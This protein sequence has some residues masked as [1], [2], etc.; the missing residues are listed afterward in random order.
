MHC[1]LVQLPEFV[2]PAHIFTEYAYFSSYSTTWVEHAGRYCEM[3][4]TRLGLGPKSFVVELGSN[5]GYLL[6]AFRRASACRCSASSPPPM[7]RKTAR[8]RPAS[9]RSTPSSAPKTAKEVVAEHGHADLIVA[10]NVLAQVPELNDFV[11]G[12]AHLLAPEGVI[13]IEVPHLE[14]LMDGEPVRYDLSRAF[15]VFLARHHDPPRCGPWPR[16]DRRRDSADAWRIACASISRISGSRHPVSIGWQTCWRRSAAPGSKPRRLCRLCRPGSAHQA[17]ASLRSH[18]GQGGRQA[19][20]RLRRAGKGQHARSTTPV[21]APISWTS[22]S[23]ATRTSTAAT[24]RACTSRSSRSKRSTQAKPD[25]ILILPWNLKQEIVA[26]DAPCRQVGRASSSF[27]SRRSRSST[28]IALPP[29]R[30]TPR[31]T[32]IIDGDAA[33]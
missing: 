1:W 32:G 24:R 6:Q 33:G 28:R 4:K 8:A 7:W 2:S 12:M 5:D 22:R 21:S 9:R 30:H 17:R 11:A 15:L 29:K 16:A 20:L 10:N 25:Y 27:P 14:R 23:T 31:L 3:I 19:H 13:T 18:Q 26:A